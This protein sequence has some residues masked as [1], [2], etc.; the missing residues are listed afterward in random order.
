MNEVSPKEER[1][2]EDSEEGRLD[3]MQDAVVDC[4]FV[5]EKKKG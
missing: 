1:D 3:Q 4:G 2:I 5:K